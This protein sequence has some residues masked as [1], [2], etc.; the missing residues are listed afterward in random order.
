LRPDASGGFPQLTGHRHLPTRIRRSKSNYAINNNGAR[1]VALELGRSMAKWVLPWD[2]NCFLT[3]DAWSRVRESVSAQPFLPY[4]IVPMARIADNKMLLRPNVKPRAHEEP[5]VVFR[6]EAQENFNERYPYGHCPKVE[7]LWRMGVPGVWDKFVL[8]EY[9]LPRPPLCEDAGKY[10]E[11]G[12]VARLTSG[13]PTLEV[14]RKNSKR[15]A[16]ARDEA[17]VAFLDMLD[18]ACVE[19]NLLPPNAARFAK[20]SPRQI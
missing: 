8:E 16:A 13:R 7:L 9:D 19:A 1:N 14:G 3:E 12:W 6:R 11:A 4:F 10:A 18:R 2:G 15:R 20:C 17:I 5:Q